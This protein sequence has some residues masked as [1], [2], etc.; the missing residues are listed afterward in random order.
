MRDYGSIS[1]QYLEAELGLWQ[2]WS[3]E[4]P[5]RYQR[6]DGSGQ[7]RAA[8]QGR[9]EAVVADGEEQRAAD[10]VCV[11]CWHHCRQREA[12]LGKLIQL[13]RPDEIFQLIDSEL[14]AIESNGR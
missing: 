9:R 6:R 11:P 4:T 3:I 14:E 5:V 2:A 12:G 13:L 1:I 10:R 7:R 8:E